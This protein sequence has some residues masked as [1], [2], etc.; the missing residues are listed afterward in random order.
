[1]RTSNVRLLCLVACLLLGSVQLGR[2][3]GCRLDYTFHYDMY[4]TESTDGTNIFTTVVTDGST[5][6]NGSAGCSYPGATHVVNSYNKIGSAGGWKYGPT[7]YMT[8]YQSVEN[9]EQIVAQPGVIYTFSGEGQVICSVFGTIFSSGLF[10]QVEIALTKVQTNL[11]N[12][13]TNK[14]VPGDPGAVTCVT[15]SWCTPATTP[16]DCPVQSLIQQPIILGSNASCAK[17]YNTYWLAERPSSGGTWSC[18]SALPPDN[19]FS[20]PSTDQAKC[21]HNP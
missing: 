10:P 11:S 12:P 3:Q 7:G 15:N 20:T 14:P 17:Y 6:G 13:G 19:S 18:I 8:G 4:L 16:P 5:S 21:T 2:A 1:M 9:D